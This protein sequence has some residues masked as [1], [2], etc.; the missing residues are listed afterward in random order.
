MVKTKWILTREAF[1][2][3][4][5]WLSHDRDEAGRKYEEIQRKLTNHFIRK[6]CD[7]PER[8]ADQTIDRVIQKLD[9]GT[10]ESSG[11][12]I[13]ICYG[14][15]KNIFREWLHE[16]RKMLPLIP[17]VPWIP[18]ANREEASQCLDLCL[19]RLPEDQ[20]YLIRRYYEEPSG[21]KKI[22]NRRALAQELK[23]EMNALRLRAKRIRENLQA[24]ISACLKGKQARNVV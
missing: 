6:N 3:F 18:P 7:C 5:L 12:P 10:L 23:L 16:Q 14:F 1:D 24:C 17:D 2:R 11:E 22:E 15:A 20:R 13:L 8:L 19:K 9:S 4:L 21:T